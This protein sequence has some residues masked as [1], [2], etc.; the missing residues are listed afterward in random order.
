MENQI[1]WP[2]NHKVTE[3]KTSRSLGKTS[4]QLIGFT[5]RELTSPDLLPVCIHMPCSTCVCVWACFRD[6]ACSFR[7][8][9]SSCLACLSSSKAS[10]SRW[11]MSSSSLTRCRY[12][13]SSLDFWATCSSI[14]W[15]T[16]MS[17]DTNTRTVIH[18]FNQW[19]LSLRA[20]IYTSTVSMLYCKTN[21][22][23]LLYK[24]ICLSCF[25]TWG[26]WL[27]CWLIWHSDQRW[28]SILRWIIWAF[29]AFVS[30]KI[31]T[32]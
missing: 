24:G 8:A 30:L 2:H 9:S 3:L 10:S 15:R 22:L 31:Q 16:W 23:L 19:A 17:Q 1:N 5:N 18:I 7:M 13:S 4:G 27:T 6:L 25:S 12:C 29:L 32:A 26:G 21:R 20:V 28:V 14:C 11:Y